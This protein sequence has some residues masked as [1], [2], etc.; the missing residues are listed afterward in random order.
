M[1]AKKLAISVK[2]EEIREIII[3]IIQILIIIVITI[4]AM[5]MVIRKGKG[6]IKSIIQINSCAIL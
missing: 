4:M 3:V 2:I 1:I 6:I 5:A